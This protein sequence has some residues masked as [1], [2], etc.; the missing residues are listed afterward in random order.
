MHPLPSTLRLTC[1]RENFCAE[2]IVCAVIFAK[3]TS[4]ALLGMTATQR[5]VGP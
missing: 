5:R 3:I 2:A 1:E 4:F